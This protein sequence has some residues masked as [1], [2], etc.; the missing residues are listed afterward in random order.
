M[1]DHKFIAIARRLN[2][3]KAAKPAA[4][5]AFSEEQALSAAI[6]IVEALAEAGLTAEDFLDDTFEMHPFWQVTGDATVH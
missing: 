3:A 5:P 2:S 4:A 6:E 1:S